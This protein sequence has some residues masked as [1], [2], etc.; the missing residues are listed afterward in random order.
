MTNSHSHNQQFQDPH[1]PQPPLNGRLRESE[2]FLQTL[3]AS[4]PGI[5][6]RCQNDPDWTLKY[7]SDQVQGLV[8]YPPADFLSGQVAWGQL[9]EP[10]DRDRVWREVQSAITAHQ[11]YSLEY[12]MRS[13]AGDQI[14]VWEQGQAVYG[15]DGTVEDLEGFITDV[16]ERKRAEA[17]S[18]QQERLLRLMQETGPAC[19]KRVS[20]DGLLLY[21]NPA[22]LALIEADSLAEAVGLS[23]F[24]LVIEEHRQG[25]ENMHRA[26]ISGET[27]TLAFEIVGFKGTRRWMETYAVPFRNPTTG[28]VEHLAV[29]H[30]ITQ[31]RQ[32]EQA[33]QESLERL[34]QA[35]EASHTGTWRVDLRTGLDRRDPSLN[36][37]LGYPGE[38][39]TQPVDDWFSHVHQDDVADMRAAW[40]RA[41]VTG[42]YDV[43]HRLIRRDGAML[44]VH[45]RGRVVRDDAGVPLYAIGAATDI[46]ERKVAQEAVERSRNQMKSFIEH[47]PAAMAML[48]TQLCYVAASRRWLRDYGLGDTNLVGRHHYDVFP[49]IRHREDWQKIHRRCLAGAIERREEDRFVRQD[50]TEQWLR[51]EVRPWQDERG[52]I[53]GIIMFTESITD[54]KQL[55]QRLRQAEKMEALG[56]LAGGIAHDFNNI[57]A[58]MIGYAELAQDGVP[59][60]S[61]AGQNI[62]QV[63]VAGRRAK[64]LIQQI[65]AFSRRREPQREVLDLGKLL[66]EAMTLL[67]AS[68][69][70]TIAI[71]VDVRSSDNTV[72]ADPTQLQQVIMNVCSNATQAMQDRGGTLGL[73]LEEVDVPPSFASMHPPLKAG[74]HMRLTITDTGVG[75]TPEVLG[76]IF[77]P[78]FTTKKVGEGT[79][80]GLSASLGIITGHGGTISVESEPGRGSTFS[81]YLPKLTAATDS[82][83]GPEADRRGG[84]ERILF[85]DDET[86]LVR[87]ADQTLGNLGYR[88]TALTDPVLALGQ[89]R[90]EPDA[91]DL[92]ITDQTMPGMTGEVLARELLRLRPSL[93]IIL[94]TGFSEGMSEQ[95][96]RKVGFR[97]LLMKPLT[98]AELD[99]AIHNAL[100]RSTR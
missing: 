43:E 76:R 29:S 28:L 85:V 54:R 63:L 5:V 20:T 16:T 90:S 86:A 66:Q 36:R 56:T 50:G 97:G 1:P 92:I 79:G 35:L 46:T 93:P 10:D 65:L 26:V 31:R 99:Q 9:I 2:R 38:P 24:D 77:D 42:L 47:A 68:I 73:R 15:A 83:Q 57:L 40:E 30:D 62:E 19:V 48:D 34:Q 14:W 33:L 59:A 84:S 89:F 25:F 23:V 44:W 13:R 6:Y 52:E 4:L 12:R 21:M 17:D 74:A 8:G 91:F 98:V 87:L 95:A 45:D 80:L 94:C 82:S 3:I 32:A 88:V 22:G 7:V 61:R 72:L 60:G 70:A 18:A 100:Q 81:V 69:P 64:S 58:A 75:M 67:R 96:A 71:R 55:E 53:G 11:P 51:W 41:Q 27:R 78:F 49:E 39:S 37:M